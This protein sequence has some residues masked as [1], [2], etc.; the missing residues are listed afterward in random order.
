MVIHKDI[1]NQNV[2]Y[3]DFNGNSPT[4]MGVCIGNTLWSFNIQWM[5]AKSPLGWLKHGETLKKNWGLFYCF[6]LVISFIH[7]IITKHC[8]EGHHKHC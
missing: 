2:G 4:K 3:G 7:G 5:V 1:T 8:D 6:Q